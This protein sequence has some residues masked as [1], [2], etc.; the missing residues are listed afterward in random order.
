MLN[1]FASSGHINYAKSARM[2]IQQMQKL[3]E[4]Y[5]WLYETFFAG[6]HV[7]RRSDRH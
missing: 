6:F 7:V 2:Y 1:L 3:A 4:E 5:P